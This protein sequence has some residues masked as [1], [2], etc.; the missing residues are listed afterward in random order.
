M[1]SLVQR[2]R[3][4][5]TLCS[6]I[7]VVI[8]SSSNASYLSAKGAKLYNENGQE[9]RLTGVNW[10]GFETT[11]MFPH[12]LWARDY[13]GVLLQVKDMGMLGVSCHQQL[14]A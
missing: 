5:F 1:P 2:L 8:F 9:V 10:F 7:L 14:M 12:G 4:V 3:F 6:V 11:N 13:H